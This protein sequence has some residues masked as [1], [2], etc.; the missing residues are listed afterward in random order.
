MVDNAKLLLLTLKN[1]QKASLI[2][3]SGNL[4]AAV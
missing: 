1:D 4:A 3:P 2:L